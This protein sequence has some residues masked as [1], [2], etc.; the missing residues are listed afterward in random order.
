MTGGFGKAPRFGNR[1][2]SAKMAQ[3]HGGRS[4]PYTLTVSAKRFKVLDIRVR[5]HK[6]RGLNVPGVQRFDDQRGVSHEHEQDV[7]DGIRFGDVP[8][9]L[10]WRAA[11][12][13]G[14]AGQSVS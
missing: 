4:G 1:D 13:T 2:K 12:S 6:L 7:V 11:T 8:G 10:G 5:V 3:L 14:A 9:R